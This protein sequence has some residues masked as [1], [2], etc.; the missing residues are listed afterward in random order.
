VRQTIGGAHFLIRLALGIDERTIKA[1]AFSTIA[2]ATVQPY[3]YHHQALFSPLRGETPH[4]GER[5]L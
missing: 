4:S 1:S 2:P 3:R 5:G